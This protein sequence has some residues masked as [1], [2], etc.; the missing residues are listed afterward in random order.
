MK[1]F[2]KSRS[3]MFV[4]LHGW[5]GALPN[6]DIFEVA[7]FASRTGRGTG[8]GFSVHGT[9]GHRYS[10]DDKIGEVG[11]THESVDVVCE[12]IGGW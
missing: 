1:S 8:S 5:N 9:H 3:I 4:K 2:K 11:G 10:K 12:I 6:Q 7:K